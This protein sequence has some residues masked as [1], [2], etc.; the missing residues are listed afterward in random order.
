M[1]AGTI[2][3]SE[4]IQ[5]AGEYTFAAAK[6]GPHLFALGLRFNKAEWMRVS[7]QKIA[8][9]YFVDLFLV[10]LAM[11]FIVKLLTQDIV[12]LSKALSSGSLKK[13]R[14]INSTSKEAEILL[15][16]T[17]TYEEKTFQQEIHH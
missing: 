15:N 13:L 9:R 4:E 6:I 8:I 12:Q 10:T 2:P 17:E 14:R 1:L 7:F 3:V 11:F 5:V 16:A